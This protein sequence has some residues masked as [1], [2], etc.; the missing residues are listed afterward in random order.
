[1]EQVKT[2]NFELYDIVLFG[3]QEE[4]E[5]LENYPKDKEEIEDQGEVEMKVI[6]K[7]RQEKEFLKSI[8][9]DDDLIKHLAN[10]TLCI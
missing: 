5:A 2:T 10:A 6:E 7:K 8:G 1:M 4:K 9:I 3:D